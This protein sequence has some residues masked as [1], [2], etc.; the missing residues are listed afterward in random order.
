MG[1]D[2]ELGII[3]LIGLGIILFLPQIRANLPGILRAIPQS[4]I[5]GGPPQI[6]GVT[7][8]IKPQRGEFIF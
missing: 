7:T 8:P 1:K 2:I 4:A 3:L 6:S 5:S